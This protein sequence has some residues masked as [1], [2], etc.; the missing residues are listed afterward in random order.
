MSKEKVLLHI[1]CGPCAIY[2]VQELLQEGYQVIGLFYN[3]NIHPLKEYLRRRQG[4]VTVSEH[5]GFRVIYKD[6]EYDPVYYFRQVV[7]REQNRCFHCYQM[8]LERTFSLAKRGKF[9]YFTTTLLYS[10]IQN[11]DR[12]AGLAE[13]ISGGSQVRFLYRD[14]RQ[15]WQVGIEL[16]HE[17]GVYRQQYC[18]CIYSERERFQKELAECISASGN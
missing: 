4:V 1:C 2:P 14:F 3:P 12:I 18:G 10:K 11:H 8:R 7:F 15:G 5:L 17:W 9:D 16:S 13:D 6:D